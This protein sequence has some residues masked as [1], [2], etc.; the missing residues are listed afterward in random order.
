M[1]KILISLL[2]VFLCLIGFGSFYIS[3]KLDI[4][5]ELQDLSSKKFEFENISFVKESNFTITNYYKKDGIEK[6]ILKEVKGSG[7]LIYWKND[8]KDEEYTFIESAGIYYKEAMGSTEIPVFKSNLKISSKEK[9]LLLS[10]PNITI[11]KLTYNKRKCFKYYV[12]GNVQYIDCETGIILYEKIGDRETK[13]MFE[14][15]NVSDKDV[16][17]PDFND[18]NL[19]I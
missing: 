17:L 14:Q 9:L 13:L 2:I 16:S 8:N 18:Y 10:N 15:N 6:T 5:D 19:A 12:Y 7:D 11:S 3:Y 4:I 1:K